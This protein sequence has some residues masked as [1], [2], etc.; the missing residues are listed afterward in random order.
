[1]ARTES[2]VLN[3]PTG[4]SGTRVTAKAPQS[5][6]VKRAAA[7][8]SAAITAARADVVEARSFI[9]V[10]KTKVKACMADQKTVIARHRTEL[11]PYAKSVKDT[12]TEL[13][14]AER[15]LLRKQIK[16][17]KLTAAQ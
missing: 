1:M 2:A 9:K 12:T 5:D 14:K 4:K 15:D 16:L 7:K 6:K 10:T 13:T 17:D 8:K 3:E 11:V